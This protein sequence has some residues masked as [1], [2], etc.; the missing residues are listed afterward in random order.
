MAP[1]LHHFPLKSQKIFWAR[2]P[3]PS[4][5]G[6]GTSL[7]THNLPL[8]VFGASILALSALDRHPHQQNIPDLPLE[9]GM[10]T[11]VVCWGRIDDPG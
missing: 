7:P 11:C 5:V 4:P 6:R 3:D 1:R 2:S 8:G 10:R 9:G